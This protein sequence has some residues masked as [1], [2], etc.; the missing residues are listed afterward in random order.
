MQISIPGVLV[1]SP[2]GNAPSPLGRASLVNEETTE[3]RFGYR[4]ELAIGDF[5]AVPNKTN[6]LILI[7]ASASQGLRMIVMVVWTDTGRPFMT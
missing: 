3:T 1:L 5:P 2:F 7:Q 6:D 4:L